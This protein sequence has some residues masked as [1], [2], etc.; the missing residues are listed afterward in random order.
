M[1]VWKDYTTEDA[2]ILIE[3]VMKTSNPQTTNHYWREPWLDAVHAFPVFMMEP[4]K[5]IMKEVMDMERKKL[6]W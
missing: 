2:K 3:K 5:N 6:G 1:K 4:I